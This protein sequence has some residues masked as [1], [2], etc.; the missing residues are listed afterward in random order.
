MPS[1]PSF[2]IFP[3]WTLTDI[4]TRDEFATVIT[5]SQGNEVSDSIW[6]FSRWVINLSGGLMSEQQQRE[7][8]AFNRWAKGR[9][10]KFWYRRYDDPEWELSGPNGEGEF[11]G[12]GDGIR[13][14][15]QA[16][17]YDDVQGSPVW[18]P[19]YALD[20]DISPLGQT[21]YGLE[22]TGTRMA[23]VFVNGILKT[24][25]ADY[26]V[27]RESGIIYFTNPPAMGA[28]VRLRGGFFAVV[29]LNQESIPTTV[30]G[31]GW[32]RIADNVLLIEPK[33]RAPLIVEA[34]WQGGGV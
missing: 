4:E 28:S 16:R 23:E 9:A 6:A 34:D 13:T 33:G 25:G 7:I 21:V 8:K 15:F 31:A 26:Y 17:I 22:A 5:P 20:H 32:Y 10:K 14:Q 2:K 11:L 12:L 30:A 19:V 27:G 29:R 1:L 18:L 3:S 24:L